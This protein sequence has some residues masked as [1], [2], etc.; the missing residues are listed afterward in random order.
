MFFCT[1]ATQDE[2]Q[3]LRVK[4]GQLD[5][6]KMKVE[7]DSTSLQ[8]TIQN[9]EMEKADLLRQLKEAQGAEKAALSSLDT[10]AEAKAV[11]AEEVR[12]LSASCEQLQGVK[13]HMDEELADQ[14]RERV[15]AI[16]EVKRLQ[17]QNAQLVSK[18]EDQDQRLTIMHS[19]KRDLG[20]ESDRL[21]QE[22]ASL[23]EALGKTKQCVAE[24]QIQRG[25]LTSTV[26]KV[27]QEKG[28]LV[29]EKLSLMTQLAQTEDMCQS[30]KD[31]VASLEASSAQLQQKNQ[32][33]NSALSTVEKNQSSLMEVNESLR[34]QKDSLTKEHQ[35][36]EQQKEEE[37]Q[38][39][40]T[41]KE[42]ELQKALIEARQRKMELESLVEQTQK[43]GARNLSELKSHHQSELRSLIN[44][45][46]EI[47]QQL[48]G[49]L[50]AANRSKQNELERMKMEQE[51]SISKF[52][53]EKSLVYERLARLQKM[54]DE[55]CEE[56]RH[57]HHQTSQLI[58]EQRQQLDTSQ[59]DAD[60]TSH[61]FKKAE[62][63]LK[64]LRKKLDLVKYVL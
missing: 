54:Y 64:E 62:D 52:S 35:L 12:M 45:H 11:I 51:T 33:L 10:V 36:Y 20:V 49:E 32:Q 41:K 57:Q 27:A 3:D 40:V 24:M 26:A 30:S 58:M 19:E 37:I 60:R 6:E 2:N 14:S 16:N 28:E 44:Q 7:R 21:K 61:E 8:L 23:T 1:A 47:I 4:M 55:K 56:S 18:M 5:S 13:Q 9:L 15:Q 43:E 46:Q 34:H 38:H 53:E 17:H 29:R 31:K 39:I 22:V 25:K 48:N 59:I 42:E 50:E 63:E